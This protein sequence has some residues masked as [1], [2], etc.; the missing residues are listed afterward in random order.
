MGAIVR[1]EIQDVI[2]IITIDYPPVNA[3]AQPVRAE[4]VNAVQKLAHNQQVAIIVLNCAGRTFTV[5]IDINEFGKPLIE[6]Y[7]NTVI[8][9]L[10]DCKKPIVAAVH[11]TAL[12][13][14][15]EIVLSCHYRC[16]LATAEL[17]FP[18][19]KLGLLPGL[20]GTQRLPRLAGVEKALDMI[21]SGEPISAIKALEYGIIDKIVAGELLPGA[22]DFAQRLVTEK[23][24]PRRVCDLFVAS[25]D[26]PP[27]FF[28]AYRERVAL[29]TRGSIALERCIQSVEAA[30]YQPFT[31]GLKQE[32][33]LF[34]E[35]MA[36]PQSKALRYL[37]LAERKSHYIRDIPRDTPRRTIRQVA[38]VGAGVMGHGIVMSFANAGV[39]VRLLDKDEDSL[40][41]GLAAIAADYKSTQERGRLTQ[42]EVTARTALIEPARDYSDIG[43]ADLIVE[44]VFEDLALKQQVFAELASVAKPGAILA[45]NTSTLDVNAIAAATGHPEDIVGLHF[46][47]PARVMRIVE[48]VRA[49]RTAKDVIVTLLDLAKMLNK[50]GVVVGV[51]YG[52]VGNRMLRGYLREANELLLE[53]LTPERIDQ[54]LEEFGLA[55]GPFAMSDLVGIDVGYRIRRENREYPPDDDAYFLIFDR[56]A[57]LGRYGQKT[58]HG[59]YRYRGGSRSPEPDPEVHALIEREAK[60]LGV[61]QSL[62]STKEIV[63]RCIF[64]LIN[65]GAHL[66]AEG[67]VQRPA[68]IDL[69][70]TRGYG[71]PAYRGGPMFYGDTVGLTYVLDFMRRYEDIYGER[72]RPA[73]LLEQLARQG[74]S[75]AAL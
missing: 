51:C 54:A 74:R 24:A 59:F 71:F 39:P 14:G 53:G 38:V 31:F 17:G 69:I 73:P 22:L 40:Q 58:G 30:V 26:L 32:R 6:P 9:A 27:D 44:T 5:G 57:E 36:S 20:G 48:I 29:K 70:W 10:E 52:F 42:A 67:I 4:L 28:A 18:E 64:P 50:T 68:D 19:V 1:S 37:F 8:T 16:A 11:G 35:C 46:F 13:A 2:G 45:T 34:I 75:F 60:R 21:V 66:L 15:L 3:L 65:E 72:W 62:I 33:A 7:L 61:E 49:E 47:N 63:C 25:A 12:G 23:A 43:D 55:M 41:R 56:L